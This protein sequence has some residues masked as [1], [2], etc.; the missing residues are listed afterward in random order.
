M[1]TT[2]KAFALF[3]QHGGVLRTH[4]ALAI[5]I[6]SKTLYAMREK[7]LIEAISRGLYLLIDESID[8]QHIDVIAACKRLPKGV[9]CLISALA[10]HELT[11]EIPHA[12]YMA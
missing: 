11:T 5:G 10:F 9:I 4:E 12:V 8:I 6:N 7:G 3:K 1:I 2:A